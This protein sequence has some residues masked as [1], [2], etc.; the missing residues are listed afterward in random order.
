MRLMVSR[1]LVVAALAAALAALWA[2]P[3]VLF[4][5]PGAND[6]IELSSL[7]PLIY[8]LTLVTSFVMSL[9]GVLRLGWRTEGPVGLGVFLVGLVPAFVL[10]ILTFGNL[11]N[12]RFAALFLTPALALLGGI[13]VLAVGLAMKSRPVGRPVRGAIRGG[14]SAVV[15]ALWI[16]FRGATDWL[17]APYGFDVYLL[18]TVAAASVLYLGGSARNGAALRV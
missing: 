10:G 8:V 4:P 16:L 11:S 5:N 12:D 15:I 2:M 3:T 7:G 17:Q 9:V 6:A 18:I 1:L 14:I 13:A